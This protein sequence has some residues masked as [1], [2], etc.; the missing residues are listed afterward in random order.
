MGGFFIY[1]NPNQNLGSFGANAGGAG[2][3][4]Q[5]VLQQRQT[6]AYPQTAE[7][8]QGAATMPQNPQPA[9][10]PTGQ[11]PGMPQ[12]QPTGAGTPP[13]QA[14]AGTQQGMPIESPE[15][16]MIIGAL[17][18]R[19]RGITDLQKPPEVTTNSSNVV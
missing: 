4:L 5:Q 12:G 18:H 7:L 2:S 11:A 10:S 14:T 15:A 13:P 8:T 19:L 17:T 16:K 6:G 9:Q 1:M 3:A